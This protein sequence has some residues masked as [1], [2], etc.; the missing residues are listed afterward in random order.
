VALF[1]TAAHAQSTGPLSITE[2]SVFALANNA[3]SLSLDGTTLAARELNPF[4]GQPPTTAHVFT[5]SAGAWSELQ[6]FNVPGCGP[7]G[8]SST[9]SVSVRGTRLVIGVT[10]GV[11]GHG[12]ARISELS[13]G[14]W[15]P[16]T[17]VRVPDDFNNFGAT[18]LTREGLVF[19]GEPDNSIYID[20]V[21][22]FR[23]NSS[24]WQ[25]AGS[26]FGPGGSSHI[27]GTMLADSGDTLL[28]AGDK[29]VDV[30]V[31]G[32]TS[33]QW[34]HQAFLEPATTFV[35]TSIAI[36]GDTAVVGYLGQQT[37]GRAAVY[38][39]TG[40]TWTLAAPLSGSDT[41]PNDQFG[42]SAGIHGDTIYVGAPVANSSQGAVYVFQRQSGTWSG[43]AKLVPTSP[44]AIGQFGETLV[45]DG[46]TLAVGANA[47]SAGAT[48]S[49]Y[50]F[51]I[52]SLAPTQTYCTAKVNSR[53][54]LPAINT[55]GV[56]GATNPNAFAI[57]ATNVLNNKSGLLLYSTV[58]AAS[59]PF[60]GGTLCL[61]TPLHRTPA[62]NSG[63][64][65]GPPDCSGTYSFN[66]N[67][68]V[69]SGLNPA[70]APGVQVWAQYYSR[71]PGDPFTVGLTDAVVFTI[72][73]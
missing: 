67:A 34:N 24:D 39:R 32:A 27:F 14:S 63:G 55:S 33:I 71:D 43:T 53:G 18:V 20:A 47:S 64:N 61:A 13:G 51:D 16:L 54:C 62:Q 31:R 66:F 7:D 5:R 36:D 60:Q 45:A 42:R 69:Q 35:I 19:V 17:V 49:L 8:V 11:E 56:P 10:D 29:G 59:T 40:T 3:P 28:V 58:G 25:L 46:T 44:V 38:A 41:L 48:G 23:K 9:M 22:I 4:V 12:D 73:S 37:G 65:A 21:H 1:A 72:G 50:L 68:L 2:N 26:L 70:L 30:R 57:G 6:S 15:G 52:T